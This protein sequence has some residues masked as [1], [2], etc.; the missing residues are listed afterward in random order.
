MYDFF[1][2]KVAFNIKSTYTVCM[3]Y[4]IIIENFFS[5]ADRQELTFEV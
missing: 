2:L 5:I 3:L 4:K 1:I